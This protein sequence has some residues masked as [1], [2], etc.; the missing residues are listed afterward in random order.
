[1]VRSRP[2]GE[3]TCDWSGHERMRQVKEKRLR[4]EKYNNVVHRSYGRSL[5]WYQTDGA[6]GIVG[7]DCTKLC[8]MVGEGCVSVVDVGGSVV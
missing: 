7:G 3:M 1:M 6:M 5:M 4:K 2:H 8:T